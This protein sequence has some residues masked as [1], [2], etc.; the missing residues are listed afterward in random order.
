[1]RL[2]PNWGIPH[3]VPV[4]VVLV[5]VLVLVVVLDFLTAGRPRT[6][7]TTSTIRKFR[8]IIVHV[9]VVVLDFLTASRPR[10]RTRTRTS[11]IGGFADR[12]YFPLSPEATPYQVISINS[13]VIA[14][15][16]AAAE[17]TLRLN[18]LIRLS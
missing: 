13:N 18:L 9:L 5:L 2:R 3:V 17:S 7:T 4:L 6:T 11:T 16:T 14:N 15:A 10:T 1:V 12:V 8:V